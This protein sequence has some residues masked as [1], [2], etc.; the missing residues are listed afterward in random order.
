[1]RHFALIAAGLAIWWLFIWLIWKHTLATVVAGTFIMGILFVVAAVRYR[2][3][4]V[5]AR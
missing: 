5:N 1:M 4:T 3:R 2:G